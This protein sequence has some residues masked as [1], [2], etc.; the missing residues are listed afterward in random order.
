MRYPLTGTSG[1]ALLVCALLNQPISA[2]TDNQ[3]STTKQSNPNTAIEETAI[4]EI[5]VRAHPLA[6]E[7]LAQP[8]VVLDADS[9]QRALGTS[10]GDTLGQLPG[11]HTSSF[12]QA[13]G[14]PVIRGLGG[15]RVKTLEDRIDSLD[16]SVTSP[17]HLTTIEPFAAKSIEVLK[18]PSTL[19]YGTGA[20]GGVVDVHT[21][22][23]PH[24]V[25]EELSL[26]ADLRGADNGNRRSAAAQAEAGTGNFAFH[27]DGFYREADNYDIPGFVESA[28]LMAQEEA[29]EGEGE[30]GEEEEVRG[31][32][33]GSEFEVRG[34]AAGLSYVGQS[35]FVGLAV[36]TY[37][38]DYGLP[39]G[40][41]EEEEGEEEEG[42][43]EEGNPTL[44]LNQTKIDFEAGFEPQSEWLSNLNLRIGWNDYEH[45][46]VEGSGEIGTEFKTEAWEG[47]LQATHS[48]LGGVRGSFGVQVSKREFSAIGEE[49]FVEPVDTDTVGVFYVGERA[50]GEFQIEAGARYEHVAH[51]PTAN[52]AR[53]F[54]LYAVSL[55]LIRP[56]GND[57]TVSAQSDLSTRA[58]VAEELYSNGPHL[59]TGSFEIGD[60]TLNEERATNVAAT[61]RYDSDALQFL[62]SAYH[63]SF[64]DYLFESPTGEEEDELPVLQWQQQ[65]ARFQGLEADLNW[66]AVNWD[67]G[68]LRFNAGL[69]L[70]D[71]R[72]RGSVADNDLP[73][74]PPLRW[75]IGAFAEWRRFVFDASYARTQRQN[76]VAIGELP[77]SGF[78]N[79]R[80]YL[81]YRAK[82]GN[83]RIE[84]FVRGDNLT[85][86]EQRLHTSFIKDLAPQPGRTIEG[87][88][89]I[90]L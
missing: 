46:E 43:E 34:G 51:D 86:A 85:D 1:A 75:R 38:A 72:L 87:G 4:E 89:R 90:E 27:L 56:L 33:P 29:E 13:V 2:Q 23:I 15:P 20:I 78:D 61:L 42:E 32:L 81:G 19:L 45:V 47:R 17:D 26:T 57:W 53:N 88:V 74:I 58:P 67:G 82:A 60:P 49:A 10:L 21:G 39:G 11:V 65:D 30:E 28:A 8:I 55:G 66:R 35:G 22:R 77:T 18:G 37:E 54:D 3:N 76:E 41:H 40:H 6:A 68:Q 5:V 50:L 64:D 31:T 79:L 71:A 44:D 48:E 59:A 70:V 80:A 63:T 36:S 12:G 25:P 73:R 84:I 24:A 62:V 16:V 69:D 52:D 83:S 7:G 14:R 9:L